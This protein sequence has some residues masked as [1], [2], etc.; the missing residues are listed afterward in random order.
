[1]TLRIAARA[2]GLAAAMLLAAAPVTAQD[3][4]GHRWYLAGKVVPGIAIADGISTEGTIPGT[5][6]DDE[7]VE[8]VGTLGAAIGYDRAHWRAELEYMWRYRFDMDRRSCCSASPTGAMEITSFKSD[9][10]TQGVLFNL[11]YDLETGALL[12]PY[13]GFGVG[14][15]DK[16]HES[17]KTDFQPFR[18]EQLD[19]SETDF[20]WSLNLG[21]HYEF[22]DHWRLDL[23][24]RYIDL[25]DFDLGTFSD[26]DRLT[27]DDHT[28]HD[29]SFSLHYRF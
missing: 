28:S 10:Q 13:V 18:K 26:G 8:F 11:F 14:V 4:G 17:T 15:V 1:M 3:T 16:E 23:G 20:V 5:L 25:G 24:Y 2:C 21:L 22:D 19:N 12:D 9:V 29:L 6:D 7:R 27:A